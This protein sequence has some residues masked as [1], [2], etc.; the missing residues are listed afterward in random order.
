MDFIA[1]GEKG[2]I[3]FEV[4]RKRSLSS[5]DFRSLINFFKDY[6]MAKLYCFYGGD[7]S[8]YYGNI[9][10]YPLRKV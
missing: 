5:K 6:L 4:K 1:Y 8:E 9:T 10:A 3:A 2:L 7:M